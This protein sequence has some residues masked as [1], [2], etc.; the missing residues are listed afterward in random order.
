MVTI[1]GLSLFHENN[2]FTLRILLHEQ[3]PPRYITLDYMRTLGTSKV[4]ILNHISDS[5][6]ILTKDI[7]VP[8]HI[9]FTLVGVLL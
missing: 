2:I 4:D 3:N 6:H 7:Y 1:K 8:P 5:L 9:S